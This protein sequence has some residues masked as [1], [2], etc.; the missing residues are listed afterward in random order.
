[1]MV[2]RLF[3]ASSR[4]SFP[5]SLSKGCFLL[6]LCHTAA[7]VHAMVG[8]VKSED[9][10]TMLAAIAKMQLFSPLVGVE[11]W[12]GFHTSSLRMT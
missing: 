6:V 4:S 7:N 11:E 5:K 1:M 12:I 8:W 2:D 10:Q 3:S 9:D